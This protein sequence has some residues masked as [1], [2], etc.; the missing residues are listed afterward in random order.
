MC[1]LALT[2]TTVSE[3]QRALASAAVPNSPAPVG[4]AAGFG[5]AMGFGAAAAGVAAGA[6]A[7]AG[8]AAAG[9]A[10]GAGAAAA[11]RARQSFK[12]SCHVWPLVALLA[13]AAFHSSPHCLMMLCACAP[14]VAA[15]PTAMA[16]TK[17]AA[18]IFTE[19]ILISTPSLGWPP[20]QR[21]ALAAFF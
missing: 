1:E 8:A 2:Q 12:N 9:V 6:G 5:T 10:A 15:N 14:S 3:G 17:A 20:S 19:I 13:L 16:A 18:A 7:A 21:R 4:A 11:W